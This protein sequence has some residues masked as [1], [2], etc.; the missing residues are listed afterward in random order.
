MAGMPSR[1]GS[2]SMLSWRLAPE[3]ATLSGRPVASTSRWYLV[4]RLPRSVGFGPVNAPPFRPHADR[5]EAGPRPVQ[6]ALFA[7]PV[8]HG[9]VDPIEDAGFGPL[10]HPPPA[11]P[12]RSVAE[13]GR[14]LGP[15]DPGRQHER[16]ALEHLAIRP[17]WPSGAA[18][19]GRPAGWDQ[20]LD[21]R[22]ELVTDQP[23]RRGRDRR[24]HATAASAGSEPEPPRHAGPDPPTSATSS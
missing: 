20:R 8:E 7:E 1:S 3:T 16:D 9:L 4:P 11:G 13:L 15:A 10:A 2:T 21:Q 12:A 19:N 14:Q 22:P 23:R 24:R 18:V 17:P 5:V 6:P